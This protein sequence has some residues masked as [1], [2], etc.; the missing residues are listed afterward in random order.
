MQAPVFL[1]L[2]DVPEQTEHVARWI[3]GHWDHKAGLSFEAVLRDVGGWIAAAESGHIVP[4][5]LV[6]MAE[7]QAVSL[8]TLVPE[9][10]LGPHP[11]GWHT[12]TPW[13]A[14]MV[15]AKG[16]RSQAHARALVTAMARLAV[17]Q[18][19]DTAYYW[20]ESGHGTANRWAHGLTL[21]EGRAYGQPVLVARCDLRALAA[22]GD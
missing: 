4:L 6:G 12:H 3:H 17:S 22:A 21:G 16:W 18:G 14:N 20:R 13:L 19:I 8:L 5:A 11:L 9:D 1:P 10:G 15:I 7:G 2:N